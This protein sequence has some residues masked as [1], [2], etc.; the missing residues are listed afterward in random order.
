MD[1]SAADELI[2]LPLADDRVRV[3]WRVGDVWDS[4]EHVDED[5][6]YVD[7]EDILWWL[8]RRGRP[9]SS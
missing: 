5:S 3:D 4:C 7:D 2:V 9:W 1:L 6:G 8:L